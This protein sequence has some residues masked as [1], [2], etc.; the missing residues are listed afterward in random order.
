MIQKQLSYLLVNDILAKDVE[1]PRG[2]GLQLLS[3]GHRL[4]PKDISLLIKYEIT[5][6]HVEEEEKKISDAIIHQVHNLWSNINQEFNESYIENLNQ[7]KQ[8]FNSV[9]LNEDNSSIDQVLSNFAPVLEGALNR[10]YLLHVLHKIRG[11]DDYTYRHCLNVSL[12]S[13][14]IGKLLGLSLD[15]ITELSQAGLLHDI[16][17]MKISNDIINKQGR[18]TNDEYNR[19]QFHTTY[20]YEVLQGMAIPTKIQTAA[21]AH[22]ERLDG[23]GYPLGLKGDEIPYYA[24]IIAIADTYDA[25]CSDRVYHK[26]ESPYIAI[27]ELNKGIYNGHFNPQVVLT[28]THF[29]ISGYVGYPVLLNNGKRAK[30]MLIH[31]DEPQRP[32]LLLDGEYIDLRKKRELHIKDIIL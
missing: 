28:F 19:I 26:K 31:T 2:S 32:L 8:L 10:S 23:S 17:K 11:F 13:G 7:V 14:V 30:I 12:L 27:E 1:D 3:K 20:G 9:A 5:T 6:V 22:H 24:Q 4:T 25:I 15:E 29:L 16:G 18:L 21:L